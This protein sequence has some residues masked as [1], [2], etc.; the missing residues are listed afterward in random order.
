MRIA[1]L[2]RSLVIMSLIPAAGSAQGNPGIDSTGLPGDNF[3]LQGALA[4]FEKAQSPEGFEQL[5]NTESNHVNN[6]DLNE[7][8]EID[9]LR[10]IHNQKDDAHVFIIQAI[11]SEK[12]NQ[13]VAVIGLEKTGDTTAVLQITGDEDIYGETVIV[14]PGEADSETARLSFTGDEIS[15]GPA[16]GYPDYSPGIIIN[17]WFWPTVRF[18]HTPA[19]V[20][21]RSPYR[22]RHYPGW[23]RPWRPLRWHA[24][25]PHHY[26]HHH[27]FSVVR[28]HRVVH[29]RRIYTPLRVTSSTVRTRHSTS[30]NN[31]RVTRTRTT[32]TGPRGH[33]AT[34]KSTTVR[35]KNGKVKV[36]KTRRR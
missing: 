34:R 4:L 13:D 12:E 10:V 32:V 29:A 21:W 18:I 17:V 11:V 33:Q 25:R 30:V 7:D 36:T 5:L 20:T 19:Y 31:Y 8:G 3:S 15:H 35:G 6:L 9:Y 24:F 23:W 2:L 14:E 28:T 16:M 27:R 26:H 22:W 1:F